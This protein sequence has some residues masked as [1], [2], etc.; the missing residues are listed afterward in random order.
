MGKVAFYLIG[1]NRFH[2]KTDKEEFTAVRSRCRQNYK[3]ENLH[4]RLAEIMHV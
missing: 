2:A 4:C 3:F 1:T